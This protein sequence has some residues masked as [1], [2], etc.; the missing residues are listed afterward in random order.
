MSQDLIDVYF[1]TVDKKQTLPKV[2]NKVEKL[3]LKKGVNLLNITSSKVKGQ[4]LNNLIQFEANDSY[5]TLEDILLF[6]RSLPREHEPYVKYWHDQA[7]EYS[8]FA[9]GDNK[10]HSFGDEEEVQHFF[11][12]NPYTSPESHFYQ[13]FPA[14]NNRMFLRLTIK[15]KG[16]MKK[17]SLFTENFVKE[18]S[19]DSFNKL[20]KY[21]DGE[22]LKAT[23]KQADYPFYQIELRN[24]KM[25]LGDKARIDIAKSL[26]YSKAEGEYLFLGFNS[27]EIDC[28]NDAR[29]TDIPNLLLEISKS[30]SGK[31][32][33]PM[34]RKDG[35]Q[36]FL[37]E[38]SRSINQY[39]APKIHAN[40][41][42]R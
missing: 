23:D 25:S 4:E 20:K 2:R 18:N 19:D 37:M 12:K 35:K 9:I 24:K 11:K 38:Y 17:L 1:G 33:T 32:D 21:I 10:I 22:V 8:Y 6:I 3:L 13:S 36:V 5:E 26:C 39:P 41:W 16:V 15:K 34:L 7:G 28:D 30:I 14:T 42:P 29:V 27:E 40:L 31:I